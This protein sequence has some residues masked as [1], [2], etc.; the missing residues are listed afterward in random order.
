MG[1]LRAVNGSICPTVSIPFAVRYSA[2][3][4]TLHVSLRNDL[5]RF[6]VWVN[7]GSVVTGMLLSLGPE[8]IQPVIDGLRDLLKECGI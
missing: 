2:K 3:R 1:N 8:S 5:R 4:T 7:T 6:L